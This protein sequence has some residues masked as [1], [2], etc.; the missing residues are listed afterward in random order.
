LTHPRFWKT[1]ERL[2]RG[3]YPPTCVLCGAQG[4][5]G[6]DLCAP[7]L[8]DL[9]RNR[10]CCRR[11]ALPLLAALPPGALCGECQRRLPPYAV[12]HAAFRYEG[13]LPILVGGAKFRARLN[14]ARLLGQCLAHA[15]RESGAELPALIVPVPLHAQRLRERGYNQAFELARIIG[16]ERSIPVDSRSCI[17]VSATPPQAGLARKE[18]R[19]NVRGAFC[20]L[21][22]PGVERGAILDDVVTTGSTVWS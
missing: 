3:L 5:S 16:R 13:P 19:R 7:C 17:R 22:P 9:P 15:L 1:T 14:L 4:Q 11:C 10:H 6:L 8:A 12:C 2:L 21:H 18:R 20:V